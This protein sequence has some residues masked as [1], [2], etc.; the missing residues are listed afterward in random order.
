MCKPAKFISRIFVGM[1]YDL[2]TSDI[3]FPWSSFVCM[4]A[5]WTVLIASHLKEFNGVSLSFYDAIN[6]V[7][8]IQDNILGEISHNSTLSKVIFDVLLLG[9]LFPIFSLGSE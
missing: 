6:T 2:A 7:F 9:F 8:A 1:N 3:S 5:V 4:C